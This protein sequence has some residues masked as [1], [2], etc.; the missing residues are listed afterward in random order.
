LGLRK[1]GIQQLVLHR[2]IV[3]ETLYSAEEYHELGLHGKDK[4]EQTRSRQTQL[5]PE[6]HCPLELGNRIAMRD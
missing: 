6:L 5:G 2:L 4:E 1:E 3:I